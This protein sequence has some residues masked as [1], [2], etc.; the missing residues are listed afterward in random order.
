MSSL[1]NTTFLQKY[2]SSWAVVAHAFNPSTWEAETGGFLSL[3]PLRPA[4]STEWVPEQQVLHKEKQT[5]KK[6]K[7]DKSKIYASW[8]MD[9]FSRQFNCQK[10][11]L[12]CSLLIY[13]ISYFIAF[14]LRGQ[15]LKSYCIKNLKRRR[16]GLIFIWAHLNW[17][18]KTHKIA[19]LRSNSKEHAMKE[20]RSFRLK[21]AEIND[22]YAHRWF[23]LWS[24]Q[25]KSKCTFSVK[26]KN[27]KFIML[28]IRK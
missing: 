27:S 5:K 23:L 9:D 26:H 16:E 20:N 1:N 25:Q 10:T 19:Q 13:A 8:S 14:L 15:R 6:K 24:W 12:I 28:S 7:K 21:T 4:W 2:K 22:T 18:N 11:I 3:R 17:G